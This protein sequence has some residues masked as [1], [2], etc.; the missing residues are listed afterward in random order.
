MYAEFEHL[1]GACTGQVRIVN[2]DFATIGRHESAEVRFDAERDLDVSGRHAAV[3]RQGSDWVLRDLGSTNGTF[4]NGVRIRSDRPL[5]D[6]DVIRFGPAG[7]QLR[8]R[9]GAGTPPD[10]PPTRQDP[11]ALSQA[12]VRGRNPIVAIPYHGRTAE[13]VHA[14]VGRRVSIW[15]RTAVVAALA[16]ALVVGVVGW[17][18]LRRTRLLQLQREELLLRVDSL[19]GRLQAATTG[20]AALNTALEQARE[21]A[22]K[23]RSS[24]SETDASAE[25]LETLSREITASLDRHRGVI[26]TAQLDVAAVTGSRADGVALVVSELQGRRW[27]SGTGFTVLARGDTG[28]LATSRHLVMDSAGNP[29]VR[30]GA[31]FNR[32]AQNFRAAL[33][34]VSDSADLALIRVRVRG[35][36][37]DALPL[38]TGVAT[39][40]PV[41]ALGYPFGFDFPMGGDWRQV[42][43][44]AATFSGTVTRAAGGTLEID[45]Y[46][47]T[48]SSG[49]PLLDGTGAVVGVIYG[50]DP[51]SHG[52]VLYAVPAAELAALMRK[53]G[54]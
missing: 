8:F 12:A 9:L 34:A 42:G 18:G 30:L 21:E 40:D 50:G 36:V 39:G 15:R 38:A 19:M 7:P 41:A 10:A 33:V 17:Y 22:A 43:V 24:I 49:S 14:E 46:G 27:V 48:G 1:D 53:A 2:R 28:W 4:V 37:P 44:S 25:R 20:V 52:R 54:L 45:G 32:T 6:D 11:E 16:L 5:L 29:A 51:R 13:R 47:A 26:R 3:F 23:L 31:I 35:G